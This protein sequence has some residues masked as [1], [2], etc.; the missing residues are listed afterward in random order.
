[1]VVGVYCEEK[2]KGISFEECIACGKCLPS[3]LIKSLRVFDYKPIRN[4]YY[5]REVIGCLRKAYF[6]R[7]NDSGDTYLTLKEL[8]PRKR[9][10]LMGKITGENG[11]DELPGSLSYNVDGE[12]LKLTARLDLYDHDKHEI[13]ELKSTENIW[14]R[15]LPKDSD[16]LQIQSYGVIFKKILSVEKL[17]I[18]YLGM[19]DFRQVEIPSIDKSLWLKSRVETLHRSIRDSK[20]PEEEKSYGCNFCQYQSQCNQIN[21]TRPMAGQVLTSIGG[22]N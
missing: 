6:E 2:S 19:N 15:Y 5:V 1:M 17:R 3:Q 12:D 11:W 13:I 7:R 18:V 21:V 20:I 16:V 9:G 8:Y 4:N 22:K 10:D 14:S